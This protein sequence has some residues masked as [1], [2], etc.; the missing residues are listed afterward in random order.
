MR[1]W[2]CCLVFIL[3]LVASLARA[4]TVEITDDRGGLVFAYQL[5]WEQLQTQK[6]NVRIAGRCLS[7]CTIF[8]GYIPR[9]DICVMPN[10]ALGFH[11][12]T[13]PSVTKQLLDEYPEDIRAWIDQH[14]GLTFQVIWMQAPEIFHYFRKCDQVTAQSKTR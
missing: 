5:K 2:Q 7:A 13:L 4:E 12:A 8:L 3:S 1:F 14:G 10:A 9:R 6:V 11:L